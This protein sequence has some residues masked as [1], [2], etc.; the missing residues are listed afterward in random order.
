MITRIILHYIL[1]L[2]APFVVY[3]IWLSWARRRARLAE[4]E[5]MP[6]WREAPLTWLLI[7]GVALFA[8]SFVMFGSLGNSPPESIYHPPEVV[9][10]KIVPSWVE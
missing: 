8:A 3:W 7:S 9:D 5:S 2:A 10:G 1:P 4:Q 6:H